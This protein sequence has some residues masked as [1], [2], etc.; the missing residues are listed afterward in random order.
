MKSE[1]KK[2]LTDPALIEARDYHVA[3]LEKMFAGET[4]E[5]PFLLRGVL[6]F[7]IHNLTNYEEWLDASLDE[8]AQ[9][10]ELLH[11][12]Y[13]FQPLA[14]NF[15]P[16]GVHFIDKVFHADVFDLHG[17]WQ[18]H[19]VTSAVGTLEPPDLENNEAWQLNKNFATAFLAR[20]VT[21]PFFGQPT[22]SSALNI[23]VNLYGQELLLAMKT[24]P[25]A[26]HH[27]LKIIN[28]TLCQ[29]HQ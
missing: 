12:P 1:T 28:D 7:S 27:D 18:V 26:A 20:E 8:L 6:C 21:V 3:R 24:D 11:N 2:I 10:A 23:G 4:L 29:F 13:I 19:P 17:S 9:K 22:I 16:W 14:I 5:K 15:D 25:A